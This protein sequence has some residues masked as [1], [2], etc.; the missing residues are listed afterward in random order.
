[1]TEATGAR[2]GGPG[3]LHL[4]CRSRGADYAGRRRFDDGGAPVWPIVWPAARFIALPTRCSC[5][6]TIRAHPTRTPGWR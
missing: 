4:H 2:I 1:M 5:F 3:W 6:A